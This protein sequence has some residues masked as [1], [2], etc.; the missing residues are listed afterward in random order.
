MQLVSE[1]YTVTLFLCN[2]KFSVH[3]RYVEREYVINSKL[4]VRN[5]NKFD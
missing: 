4:I 1:G 5:L 3:Y 2:C